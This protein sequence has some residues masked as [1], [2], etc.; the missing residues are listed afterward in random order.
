MNPAAVFLDA[1]PLSE[2]VRRFGQSAEADRC[3]NRILSLTAAGVLVCVSE[4]TD[5]EVRREL[6]R[7]GKTT[8]LARLDTLLENSLEYVPITTPTM[9]EAAA[10]WASARNAG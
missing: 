7:S 5:Y 1:G 10:L 6:M 8:S 4:I 2:I 3:R 9:R